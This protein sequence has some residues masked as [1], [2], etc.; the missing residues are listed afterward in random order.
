[1]IE[2][3][4]VSRAYYFSGVVSRDLEQVG[5]DQA[6]DGLILLNQLLASKSATGD[7]IPACDHGEPIFSAEL[8]A[9]EATKS[10]HEFE[11][12][13]VKLTE[14]VQRHLDATVKVKG[15]DSVLSATTYVTSV[16]S[17]FKADGAAV[18]KWRDAVWTTCYSVLS[19][20]KSGNREIPTED[21][22]QALLPILNW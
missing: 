22:L 6:P 13:V 12:T 17:K 1:M 19:E 14:F 2:K 16:N 15:Y 8:K 10:A 4:L 9:D 18:V 21:E 3:E 5:G 7:E 20:V 11:L